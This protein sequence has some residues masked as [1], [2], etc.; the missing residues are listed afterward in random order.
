MSDDITKEAHAILAKHARYLERE[1]EYLKG[2]I[3]RLENA[4]EEKDI[5]IDQL[6]ENL[7]EISEYNQ[8]LE[9]AIAEAYLT[10]KEDPTKI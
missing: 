2:D 3:I 5:E 1:L 9:T 6:T 10:S 7:A 4:L 8:E